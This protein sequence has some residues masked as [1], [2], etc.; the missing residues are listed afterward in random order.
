MSDILISGYYGFKN[1]GDEL[2]LKA[3]ISDLRKYSQDIKITV[4]SVTPNETSNKYNV[5]AVNRWNIFSIVKETIKCKILISGSGGLFQDTTG[6]L[7][8]LYYLLIILIAKFFKKIVFIYAV[9][10]DEIKYA[11]NGFLIKKCFNNVH[12]ITVRTEDDKIKLQSLAVNKKIIVTS[13]PVFGLELQQLEKKNNKKQRVG[14]ILRKTKHWKK[15]VKIF[16]EVSDL[17]VKNLKAEVIFIPFQLSE[18][19]ELLNII[20]NSTNVP[21]DIFIWNDIE[22][23]L[24][25]F[26][27]LDMVVSMRLH[28]LIL[29][30]KYK[31]P[32]VAISRYS[33]IKN[34]LRT[35]GEPLCDADETKT[36]KIYTQILDKIND[37]KN[38]E[39]ISAVVDGLQ[40]RSKKTAQLCVSMLTSHC[41]MCDRKF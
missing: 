16:S 37:R 34:F 2:I 33:K 32:F 40:D 11:F 14:I 39:K 20:K 22:E 21:V 7:S 28:G 12:F 23:L 15:D 19:I 3:I 13:D 6:T 36:E 29:A 25:I 1:I 24:K 41:N 38:L 27:Q 35:I 4:L 5:C 10:I 30:A 8:L 18:D 26:S 17:I 31:I 9:G